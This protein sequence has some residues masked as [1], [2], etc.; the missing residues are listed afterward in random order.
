MR[1]WN[2]G[3]KLVAQSQPIAENLQSVI[4]KHDVLLKL[5]K[6]F[7][8]RFFAIISKYTLNNVNLSNSILFNIKLLSNGYFIYYF[9]F[10]FNV[11]FYKLFNLFVFEAC[12]KVIPNIAEFLKDSV[13][14]EPLADFKCISNA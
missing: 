6:M 9:F 11:C 4:F 10:F 14:L 3:F 2:I 13:F 5:L 7:I 1:F 8:N 12:V